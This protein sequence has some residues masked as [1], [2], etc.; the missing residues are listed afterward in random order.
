MAHPTEHLVGVY[1][2]LLL[3]ACGVALVAKLLTHLPYAIFLTLVGLGI[4]VLHIGPHPEHVGFSHDL[5]YFVFLP[6]ILF[7]G[8]FDI[9]P[10]RLVRSLPTVLALAVPGVLVSTLVIGGL[11]WWVGGLT[12]LLVA[13][14]FGALITPTDPV[15]VLALF[16]KANAPTDLRVLVE[17]ESMFNDGTGVVLFTI[18]LEVLMGREVTLGEGVAEFFKVAVGGALVGGVAGLGVLLLMRKLN[19]H[20]LE[21]AICLV[22]AFGAFWLAETLH[23]SGVIATVMA[24]LL[25]GSYGRQFSMSRKTRETIETFFES[26]DFVLNSFL[27]ILIGLELREIPGQISAH[28]LQLVGVAIGAMLVSRAV[29][30][31]G[32]MWGLKLARRPQARGWNHVLFWSGL[33][34]SIPIALLLHLPSDLP[35]ENP[36]AALR[37]ELIY[38]GFGCVFFSLVVQ[39][40]TMSPLLRKLGVA[41]D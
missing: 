34:G 30:T 21:N 19:D 31:Y 23:V 32:V 14:L 17:G 16:R 5:I 40:L 13:L 1:I 26:I 24:G 33:R 37:P 11:M 12:S 15:S 20:L 9:E 4:G 10:R 29:V 6:P 3:L 28:P 39:G 25:M 41:Q 38:A 2:G 27:F 18:F 36:L 7:Q 35:A 22:L 8:A